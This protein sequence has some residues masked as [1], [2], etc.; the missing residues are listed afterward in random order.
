MQTSREKLNCVKIKQRLFNKT[1]FTQI[2][3]Q[4]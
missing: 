3:P 1:E 4:Q 2:K